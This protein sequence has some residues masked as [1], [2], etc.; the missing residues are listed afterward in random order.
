MSGGVYSPNMTWAQIRLAFQEVAGGNDR[1]K[2][3]EWSYVTQGYR[4]L[5][6][7]VEVPEAFKESADI[8]VAAGTDYFVHPTELG[9][10]HELYHLDTIYNLTDGR[11]ME[12]EP[13]GM[14]G[15]DRYLLDTGAPPEGVA[16]YYVRHG[17]RVYLRDTPADATDFRVRYRMQAP[18][19]TSAD[20]NSSPATPP[21]LD[22]AIVHLAA[23]AYFEAHPE[24]DR[25]AGE[26]QPPPSQKYLASAQRLIA[27]PD[28]VRIQDEEAKATTHRQR[29]RG[30]SFGPWSRR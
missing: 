12:P 9:D 25:P 20:A 7:R 8:T 3:D 22:W 16:R 4:E 10:R 13:S 5:L 23:V 21:H 6:R 28:E 30:Y 15:R 11:P 26:N 29:L 18:V 19:L 1:V 14:A 24:A 2:S 17:D 27:P